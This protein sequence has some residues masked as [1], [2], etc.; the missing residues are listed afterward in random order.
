M[1]SVSYSSSF[2]LL[3]IG[4]N[5]FLVFFH[6]SEYLQ[7]NGPVAL[8]AHEERPLVLQFFRVTGREVGETSL[9]HPR[10]SLSGVFRG[11]V[12]VQCFRR[13]ESRKGMED[14][15]PAVVIH[16]DTEVGR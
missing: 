5:L 12:C 1:F 3:I 11:D 8:P 16:Q 2:L 13:V 9:L 7:E 15:A 14:A 10:S 4:C 6:G